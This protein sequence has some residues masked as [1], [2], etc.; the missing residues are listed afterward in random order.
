V[1]YLPRAKLSCAA[2][3]GESRNAGAR[4]VESS[5]SS[6]ASAYFAKHPVAFPPQEL[7]LI[8]SPAVTVAAPPASGVFVSAVGLPVGSRSVTF[9]LT[10]VVSMSAW[11]TS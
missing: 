10:A 8:T 5:P 11:Q 4:Q 3:T 1:R 2:S 7:R 9:E 6:L